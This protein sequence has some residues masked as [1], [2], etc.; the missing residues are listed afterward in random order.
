MLDETG[1]DICNSTAEDILKD[2]MLK[3]K[4][5]RGE[6]SFSQVELS[7]PPNTKRS[8]ALS[9]ISGPS[10]GVM[11]A[12]GKNSKATSRRLRYGMSK[13]STVE[14]LVL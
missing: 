5:G 3:I 4:N 14:L 1:S 13:E 8:T 11:D 7:L 6:R 12:S 9:R 2:S 10:A